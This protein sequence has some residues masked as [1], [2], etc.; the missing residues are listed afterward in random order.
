MPASIRASRAALVLCLASLS[1][2]L[3]CVS[4]PPGSA[5]E[6]AR[7][8]QVRLPSGA[9]LAPATITDPAAVQRREIE[10]SLTLSIATYVEDAKYFSRVNRLPGNPRP[11]EYVLYF[12]FSRYQMERTPHPAYFPLAILTLTIYIWVGGP[13]YVDKSTLAG[14]LVVKAVSGATLVQV[15]DSF[16]DQHDVSF[17]SPDY[18][19]PTGMAARTT[20]VRT[21]LDRAVAELES[22]ALAEPR[23]SG[24]SK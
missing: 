3:G 7:P 22:R 19:F 16:A 4:V 8:A 15:S 9:W 23:T 17:N 24:V 2:S 12:D 11:D 5:L 6:P 21:L 20:L 14:E 13:I 1:A 10:Q 18:L